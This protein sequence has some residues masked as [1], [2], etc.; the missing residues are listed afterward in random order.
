MVQSGLLSLAWTLG[1]GTIACFLGGLLSYWAGR[2][3]GR[4]I[5]YRVPFL[6]ITPERAGQFERFLKK[7]GAKAVFFARFLAIL[8]PVTGLLAGIGKI[9]LRSFL[10]YNLAGSAAYVLT[11]TLL[12][13]FFGSSWDVLRIWM[14]RAAAFA[15]L[16]LA[17]LALVNFLLHNEALSLFNRISKKK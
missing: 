8:H 16:I 11:Y 5:L 4:K 15:I 2:R 12:G 6:R 17:A 10:A 14:G 9:P 7:H 3:A 1:A 13:Y